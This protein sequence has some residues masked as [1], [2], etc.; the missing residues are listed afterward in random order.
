MRVAFATAVLVLV[1]IRL[2]TPSQG[3]AAQDAAARRDAVLRR[4]LEEFVTLTPGTGQ[5]PA[6]FTMG[7]AGEAPAAEKPA[8]KV[9]LQGP[10]AVA[11]YEVTQELYEAVM[12]N[13]PSRW[14]GP[15][16]A[17]DRVTWDEAREFCRKATAELRQRRLLAEGELVRLPS[18]AEWEYACRAGTTTRYSFGD[19]ADDLREYAWFRGNSKGEDPPV[20]R[21]KPN[22]WGLYDLHGYVWEWCQDS[23][24]DGYAKAPETSAAWEEKDAKE[25]VLRG[26]SWA[27]G[28]DSCRS[29]FRHHQPADHRSD[30]VGFRCVRTTLEK[31]KK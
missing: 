9:R 20:G 7:T 25:R 26:G 29:A 17:V 2:A 28:A 1:L 14:K 13:N 21:K 23:W 10:F 31:E 5:F 8:H 4:F 12:G 22:A 24:H 16:N 6:S 19:S 11:R 18:E 30:A 3:A 27:D 15:R